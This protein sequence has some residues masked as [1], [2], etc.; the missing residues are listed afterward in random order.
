MQS[1]VSVAVERPSVCPSVC[2]SDRQQQRWLVG[3]L[4]SAL[5]VGDIDRQLQAPAP[6]T[7]CRRAGSNVAAARRSA[8]NAGSVKLTADEGG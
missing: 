5:R 3:L 6:R 4:L 2:H 1:R 7:S 8:S